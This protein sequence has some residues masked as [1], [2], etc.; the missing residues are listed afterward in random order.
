M[1]ASYVVSKE[2]VF[3]GGYLLPVECKPWFPAWTSW[4]QPRA[5]LQSHECKS[6]GSPLNLHIGRD[7]GGVTV[8]LCSVCLEQSNYKLYDFWLTRLLSSW[9]LPGENRLQ[10]E[11]CLFPLTFPGCQLLQLCVWGHMQEENSEQIPL[12]HSSGPNSLASLLFLSKVQSSYACFNY[13]IQDFH[14]T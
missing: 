7:G 14:F 8:F 4:R 3:E 13:N 12:Y 11:S 9:S 6:V 10:L 5:S 1:L 2:T